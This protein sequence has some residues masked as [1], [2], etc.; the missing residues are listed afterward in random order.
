MRFY[1]QSREVNKFLH[2]A[3]SGISRVSYIRILALA[4]IDLVLTLPINITV[5]VMIVLPILQKK[6]PP[7]YLPI[8]SAPVIHTWKELKAA[9]A[10]YGLIEV[11]FVRWS[12]G[13]LSVIVFAILGCTKGARDSYRSAFGIVTRWY[14]VHIMKPPGRNAPKPTA[15]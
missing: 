4:S 3:E 11:Y 8:N 5:V 7:V 9:G 15:R 10:S 12:T 13:L 6:P 1:Q 14:N 2:S